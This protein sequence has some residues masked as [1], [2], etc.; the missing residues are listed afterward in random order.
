MGSKRALVVDDERQAADRSGRSGWVAQMH[1][2]LTETLLGSAGDTR[3]G[4][5]D[6]LGLI[7]C[8]VPAI[9]GGKTWTPADSLL[10]VMRQDWQQGQKKSSL[11][12]SNSLISHRL[13]YD[14]WEC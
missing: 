14:L 10:I 12:H 6:T 8:L 5:R 11:Y 2:W 4:A 7:E 1:G 9:P 3:D 13:V